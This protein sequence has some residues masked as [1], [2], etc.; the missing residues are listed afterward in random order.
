MTTIKDKYRIIH[1]SSDPKKWCVELLASCAPFHGIVYSYGSF[2]VNEPT[3]E[4]TTPTVTYETDIIYVPER[5]RGVV[6][7]DNT[8]KEIQKLLGQILFDIVNDNLEHTKQE[9]GKLY[10]E[11]QKDD[12]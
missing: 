3:D 8:E 7:P 2:S 5:L 11:L 10:L 9:S 6:F 4:K 12:K 1:D